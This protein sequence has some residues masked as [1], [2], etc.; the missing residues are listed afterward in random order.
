MAPE[1]RGDIVQGH[2]TVPV[3]WMHTG[4]QAGSPSSEGGSVD[5][6]HTQVSIAADLPL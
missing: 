6:I 3:Y 2:G 1:G 5:T 4:V